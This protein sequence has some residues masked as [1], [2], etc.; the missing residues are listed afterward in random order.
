MLSGSAKGLGK[1]LHTGSHNNP[2][3]DPRFTPRDK[4]TTPHI[5]AAGEDNGKY[6]PAYWRDLKPGDPDY[7]MNLA[8]RAGYDPA[9][10]TD[11]NSINYRGGS[12]G[13][14]KTKDP[15]ANPGF[16]KKANKGAWT[17]D[18]S[19]DQLYE[20]LRAAQY[21]NRQNP[22]HP[23]HTPE[24]E[25]EYIDR[26]RAALGLEPLDNTVEVLPGKP[27]LPPAKPPATPPPA[28]PPP[29]PKRQAPKNPY[30]FKPDQDYI[31]EAVDQ[32]GQEA[33]SNY[34]NN[35]E[36]QKAINDLMAK[37]YS[38]EEATKMAHEF[39]SLIGFRDLLNKA[40]LSVK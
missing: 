15:R 24:T 34:V 13:G 38:R 20:R 7:Y 29:S 21:I 28:T 1:P 4:I 27:F 35:L 14:P 17:S 18:D 37:G 10:G 25:Q 11:P 36:V 22:N 9:D 2:A 12:G 8:E 19:E 31:D 30:A 23:Q 5:H 32:H 6:G 33:V 40:G 16:N 26:R 39:L 3:D